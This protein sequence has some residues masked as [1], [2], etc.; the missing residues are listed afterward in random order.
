MLRSFTAVTS[1]YFLV[2]WSSVTPAMIRFS[3]PPSL[4][5]C[6]G[7]LPRDRDWSECLPAYHRLRT[8]HGN[9]SWRACYCLQTT[10]PTGIEPGAVDLALSLAYTVLL[11]VLLG[12]SYLAL[13]RRTK[14]K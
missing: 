5:R 9:L 13:V 3:S 11:L 7:V 6:K 8:V 14:R 2:M 10:M 4:G 1:P 12:L